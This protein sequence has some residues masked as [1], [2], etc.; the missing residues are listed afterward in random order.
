MDEE[1][2]CCCLCDEPFTD[3]GNNPWPLSEREEDRCC[4]ACNETHVIP[5]RIRL[6]VKETV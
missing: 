2:G 1:N 5:A 3:F 6:W 4:H